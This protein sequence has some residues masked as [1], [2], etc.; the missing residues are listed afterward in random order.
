MMVGYQMNSE[1]GSLSASD[2][3]YGSLSR[4]SDSSEFSSQPYL[5]PKV[6][7]ASLQKDRAEI[8]LSGKTGTLS[9]QNFTFKDQV[10][11]T[12]AFCGCR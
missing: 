5:K 1:T 7:S 2:S 8:N 3:D 10:L 6:L 12:L 4:P 9:K 11:M